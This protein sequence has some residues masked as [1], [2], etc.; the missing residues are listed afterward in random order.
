MN[1]TRTFFLL[2]PFL[3]HFFFNFQKSLLKAHT[4]RIR[5]KFLQ[6]CLEEHV[7]PKS[8]LPVRLR[9]DPEHPFNDF[10][11][12]SLRKHIALT[13]REERQ[14]FKELRDARYCFWQ[15][16]PDAWKQPLLD[17]VYFRLR[18][19]INSL[20][21]HLENKLRNLIRDSDWSK[22]S[23]E[24]CVVNLSSKEIGSDVKC[25]L[26]YGLSFAIVNQPNILD[27]ATEFA[28]LEK[29]KC[30][31]QNHIDIC[32]GLLYSA[33]NF[34][35]TV[36]FPA[37]FQVALKT[38]K[39]DRD[40][41]I[42]KADKANIVVVLDKETY[43]QK[44]FDLLSD[45]ATYLELTAN[46]LDDVIKY[47]NA[48]LKSILKSNK[49]MISRFLSYGSSLP[50]L[51]GLIKTHK[52]GNPVRPIIST[53][54]SVSYKLSKYLV[55][56]LSP[57]LG[58]ISNSHIK[59][60]TDL[61]D[62]LQKVN[63]SSNHKL[64]SFDVTSLFTKVP[65]DDLLGYLAGV[66]DNYNLP[67]PTNNVIQ[68]ICLCIKN[69]KFSFNGKFYQQVFGMSMGN[70]LSPLL[71]NIYMEFFESRLIPPIW[72]SQIIWYR[73]VDD[74]LAIIKISF[75]LNGFLAI[76][77]SLVPSIKFTIEEERDNKIP[78]LD[79]LIIRYPNMFK[80]SI[81]RKPTNNLSY[82]H[83]YSGHSR[84]VKS[85]VFSSMYLR[86]LRICSPE[87][88][89]EEFS[90]IESIGNNLSYPKYFL[91]DCLC[92]AKKTFYNPTIVE[93]EP[94]K[95][96]LCLPYHSNFQ[97]VLPLMGK[98]GIRVVFRF[99][100]SLKSMLIKNSPR[101]ENNIVYR[102]GCLDCNLFY[103]GQTSK[104]ITA[105]CKNHKYHVSRGNTNNALA[106]HWLETSHA[107]DW[108]GSSPIVQVNDLT[109]RNILESFLIGS[110]KGHNLNI[111][112]GLFSLD[113][114][115]NYF[116]N[117]DLSS[118]VQRLTGD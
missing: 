98:L 97:H 78:F 13:K 83:F 92:R 65:V 99:P 61:C 94:Y 15:S 43:L 33:L 44:M 22:N 41:H 9:K 21:V 76:I 49:D 106:V 58:T 111:S 29:K 4:T 77:N 86:A 35:T 39:K 69:C 107:I 45:N 60:S 56:L 8:L 52:P 72:S 53:T 42:T 51:Y 28:K 54:G 20:N 89:D 103:L 31:Q 82:V 91:E 7:I 64:V 27:I 114:L 102:I 59:N 67:L 3:S 100:I 47:F 57:I 19:K 50:Y 85:S 14:R 117:L 38:L 70:P 71:S 68:M 55:S 40:L 5:R 116:L 93:R 32:K 36:N 95:P 96:M 115:M 62:K 79:V 88:I 12:L 63:V 81:Y 105:R 75:D 17:V 113:P 112:P 104:G 90:K 26:G 2:F 37:R 25:A 11:V 46:P 109:K 30:L 6:R 24:N 74:I 101:D 16:I 10:C 118:T 23:M 73:Y 18:E 110:T 1:A 87:Y 48:N 66:L 84:R 108:E 80:F 34:P